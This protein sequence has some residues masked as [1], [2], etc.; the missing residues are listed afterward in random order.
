MHLIGDIAKYFKFDEVNIDN[1]VFKLFYKGCFILFLMGSMVGIL[2]QYFGEPINCDFKGI[3]S[4]MASDYCW[5]HGSSYMPKRYQPHMKCI[6]DH[7]GAESEDDVA[8]TSYY[9][10]VTFVL[11]FQ[12]ATFILPYKLWQCMEGGLLA[13]FGQDANARILLENKHDI[14]DGHVMEPLVEKYVKFFRSILHRNNYYFIKFVCCE[15]LNLVMLYA[16]FYLTDVFINGNFWYYGWEAV[17]FSRLSRA[18]QSYT[19]NPMC[20]AF[21]TEVSCELPNVGA[22][23]GEQN[24]NGICVLSQNILNEKMYLAMWFWLV[25]VII[26]S[27]LCIIYRIMTLFFDGFRTGLLITRIGNTNDKF[28]RKAIKVVM[29]KCYIG[30]WFVLYQLSK[31]VNMYFFRAFMRELKHELTPASRKGSFIVKN[32]TDTLSRSQTPFISPKIDENEDSNILLFNH[33]SDVEGKSNSPSAPIIP[34]NRTS[35][36]NS[37]KET[38]MGN[39]TS[40]LLMPGPKGGAPKAV[41]NKKVL[42]KRN[43]K[44]FKMSQL[45]SAGKSQQGRSTGNK[46]RGATSG[47]ERLYEDVP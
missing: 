37:A 28:T 4:E 26:V 10:W 40:T 33:C 7:E 14:G 9:Q 20:K 24:H 6:V 36:V 45:F 29:A 32:K 38:K 19:V 3:D 31:N 30:D 2:S 46:N 5:I 13:E 25:F 8:D 17:Q 16:N 21:P 27:P 1:W 43:P 35:V 39:S 22:A 42:D 18:E 41:R 12:A 11:M 34:Q 47:S 23:G 15:C 44:S